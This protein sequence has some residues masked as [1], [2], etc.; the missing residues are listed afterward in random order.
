MRKAAGLGKS[1]INTLIPIFC[2]FATGAALILIAA[3]NPLE[4]YYFLISQSLF[5]QTGIMGTLS[6]ASPL[7]MTGL[8]VAITYKAQI[9]NM[10]VEG[11]MYIGAFAATWAGFTFT[12]LHP[13]F[14]VM[15]CLT[16]GMAA[17]AIYAAIA[18]IFKAQFHIN[19]IVV[20]LMLN[21]IAI[22]F[23]EYL[24]NGPFK[25]NIGYTATAKV[26]DSAV[27]S[28][29]SS[30]TTLSWSIFFAVACVPVF[31]F[32]Y[33]RMKLGFEVEMIGKNIGFADATGMDVKKKILIV[34]LI[35]G[36][37]SGLAGATEMLGVHRRFTPTFSTNPGL[38]WDGM[39]VA[40]MG[41]N[42]P[43]GVFVAAIFFGALKYG[44]TTLQTY[45]GVSYDII[46][47]IQSLLILFLS[48]DFIE[49]NP[50]AK[51]RLAG[52]ISRAKGGAA[53]EE[54]GGAV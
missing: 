31:W 18:G 44:S 28:R 8:A 42:N 6:Y 33:N 54:N 49:N 14:H 30:A 4:A 38:G 53:R 43:V 22:I 36:L 48:I 29:L 47:V 23:T 34:F 2:A 16:L 27:L 3:K 32:I 13:V 9:V 21:Y 26:L 12:G 11:Q 41:A 10:G 20:T 19:E 17:G 15:L 35:S 1:L 50:W 25:Q 40:L 24:T 5:T 52:M 39:L 7:I 37:V 46:T 51:R 45:M